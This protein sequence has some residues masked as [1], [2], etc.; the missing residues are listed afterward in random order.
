MVKGK[1]SKNKEKQVLQERHSVL[2][3]ACEKWFG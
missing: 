2:Q 1:V 3:K